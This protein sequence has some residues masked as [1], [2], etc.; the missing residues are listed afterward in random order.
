MLGS[1]Q[2][3]LRER[4]LFPHIYVPYLLLM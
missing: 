3:L 2:F 1:T 4:Y